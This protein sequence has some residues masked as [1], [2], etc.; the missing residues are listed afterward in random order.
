MNFL[1]KVVKGGRTFLRRVLHPMNRL[2]RPFYKSR[3][4][5]DLGKDFRWWLSFCRVFNGK[6]STFTIHQ[7]SNTSTLM[8][9]FLVLVLTGEHTGSRAFG[10]PTILCV[11]SSASQEIGSTQL[12]TDFRHNLKRILTTFN[13][14]RRYR[15]S[16]GG[17]QIGRIVPFVY[18]PPTT[19]ACPLAT[20]SALK[21][22]LP[23]VYLV[24]HAPLY[25]MH[26]SFSVD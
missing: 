18:R 25:V 10:P 3:L 21:M 26:R 9:Y 5:S 7:L 2:K 13:C 6:L 22:F 19:F 16:V 23:T 11:R 12:A 15:Q 17:L 8:H 24:L 4:T 14:T 1:S 20:F